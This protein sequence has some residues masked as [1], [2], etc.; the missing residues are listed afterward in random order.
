MQ[1]YKCEICGYI[2]DPAVG[3]SE[4]EIT[5]GTAFEDIDES[6]VCPICGSKKFDFSPLQEDSP[7]LA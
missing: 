6:W 7:A 2:Y 5:Q 3:D 4:S 1:K